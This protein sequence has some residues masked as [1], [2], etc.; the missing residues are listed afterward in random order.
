MIVSLI[1]RSRVSRITLPKKAVGQ[2]PLSAEEEEGLVQVQLEGIEDKWYL[3]SGSSV[4]VLD[5]HRQPV[6]KKELMPKRMFSVEDNATRL[7]CQVFAEPSTPDR[8]AFQKYLVSSPASLLIGRR[9]DADM[10]LD[11]RYVSQEHFRLEYRESGWYLRDLGSANGTFVNG[12]RCHEAHL[13][14]GD[15]IDVVGFRLIVARQYLAINNPD[16]SVTVNRERLIPFSPQEYVDVEEGEVRSPQWF[17]PSPRFK[18]EI[19]PYRVTIDLPPQSRLGEDMPLLLAV[20]PSMTM[21]M[22]AVVS[23]VYGLLNGNRLSAVTS[24]C[25]V[26]GMVLWPILSRKYEKKRK[27]EKE[28]LRR[29]AYR[30]YLGEL[31]QGFADARA[32]QEEILRENAVDIRTC[33]ERILHASRQLWDRGIGQ[34]DFLVLR[35]GTGSGELCREVRLPERRFCVEKDVLREELWDFCQEPQR[36]VDIPITVSLYDNPVTGV[37]GK[38]RERMEFANGLILQL[39]AMYSYDEVKLVFLTD[40]GESAHTRWLPHAYS[41]DRRLRYYADNMASAREITQWMEQE[42][43][44]REEL[45]PDAL[46][47]ICPHYVIFVFAPGLLRRSALAERLGRAKQNLGFSLVCLADELGQLPR[48]CSKVIDLR[49]DG[50]GFVYDR[51]DTSGQSTGFCPDIFCAAHQL[52]PL[53]QKLANTFLD[54]TERAAD[55]PRTLTFLELFGVGKVEHLNPLTRWQESDPT[56]SLAAPV[57]VNQYG[58]VFSLD[59]HEKQDGP[60]GLIAGMTGSGKS[61]FLITLILS[62][63]VC[64]A[65]WELAFILI[66]YKGGGMAKAVENLP[67]LAGIVTNLDGAEINRSLISIQSELRRR[68]EIFATVGKECGVSNVDIY[69]YQRMYREGSVARPMQHLLIISDEFAELKTQEPEFMAQLISAAR[70]GRSL[71]VHLLLATQKPGGV[72][73]DQIW[74]NS[75]FRVCLKV[76]DRSDSMDML[77]RPEA[78]GLA[79]TGRFY[80]QVGYDEVFEMGQSAWAGAPYLPSDKAR[81]REDEQIEVIDAVGNVRICTRLERGGGFARNPKKQVDAI[82]SYLAKIAGEE[83][84][85]AQPLWLPPLPEKITLAN[86][87]EGRS[88]KPMSG[89]AVSGEAGFVGGNFA[90]DD[91]AEETVAPVIGLLDDPANQRQQVLRLPL[92]K[93]GHVLLYGMTGSGKTTF[94]LS[95]IYDLIMHWD[96]DQ[97]QLYLLDFADETLAVFRQG[98]QV[99]DVVFAHEGEK[100]YQL[101]RL[102]HRELSRRKRR[103][104]AAMEAAGEVPREGLPTILVVIHGY[105]AFGELYDGL[106]GSLQNLLREGN[107]YGIVFLL[108]AGGVGEVGFR[109]LQQ[110]K[111]V[112]T[113][114]LA[115]ANDYGG[116]LG[117]TGGLLPRPVPGRGLLRRGEVYE[118]QTAYPLDT[119]RLYAGLQ[120]ACQTRRAQGLVTAPGIPLLPAVVDV[121]TVEEAIVFGSLCLPIGI[122]TESLGHCIYDFGQQAISLV[123]SRDDAYEEFLGELALLFKTRSGIYTLDLG[124]RQAAGVGEAI[125]AVFTELVTRHNARK[126]PPDSEKDY[127]REEPW[128]VIIPGFSALREGLDAEHRQM[129]ELVLERAQIELQMFILLADQVNAL[130]GCAYEK[131]FKQNAS[132]RDAIWIGEGFG[133]QYFLHAAKSASPLRRMAEDRLGYA[134]RRG[135]AT[136]IRPLR[137]KGSEEDA[138]VEG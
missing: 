111:Q 93:A 29:E 103:L 66:D 82:V 3:L 50:Q 61:E 84:Q 135:K 92:G 46:A 59:L 62:L 30:A 35:V 97:V 2:Y 45:S 118:F 78:A 77:K 96:T 76:Q 136:R 27:Q 16:Q 100:I 85:H 112:L 137:G 104:S 132:T 125:A 58:D 12:R 49:G 28:E 1:T 116:I 42:L 32:V 10:V 5:E 15:R 14:Y 117:K 60:H 133:D 119:D 54:M 113:L 79:Q 107:K 24:G 91:W 127:P 55:F 102:L 51:E 70:I 129:L 56:R 74:S 138:A 38:H 13:R 34:S 80:L 37:I 40:G 72:V 11:N 67:H 134:V 130:S 81:R 48:A 106:L 39:V 7:R 36:L 26:A 122:E 20:G 99:G 88:T 23:G 6:A 73:D 108:T 124:S 52:S 94:L 114:S 89:Q 98:P 41:D 57:G 63:A 43:S 22:A 8:I 115:D 126:K 69:K 47:K 21:G 109:L 86:L 33:E 65:P 71:G 31:R 128:V 68:Q 64:Y 75:R 25:M 120:E 44:V 9:E 121:L 4:T 123:L 87:R 95:L 110:F 101:F 83:G 19:E 105:A 131:W 53:S 18:R 90:E 17:T